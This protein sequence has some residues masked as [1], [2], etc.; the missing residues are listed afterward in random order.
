MEQPPESQ[1][2]HLLEYALIVFIVIVIV[3]VIL[4]A[5]NQAPTTLYSNIIETVL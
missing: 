3:V 5:L 2:S 4:A 1:Q